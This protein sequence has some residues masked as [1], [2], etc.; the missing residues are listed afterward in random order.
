M[1]TLNLDFCSSLTSFQGDCFN[2]MPNLMRLS[3]C[4]TRISNLWTTVAALSRL[5]SLVELRFQYLLHYN[6][7][8]TSY[9]S[10]S[11]MSDGAADFITSKRLPC[12]G[13]YYIGTCELTDHNFSSNNPLSNFYSFDDIMIHDVPSIKEE[14]SDDSGIDIS[15]HPVFTR[16]NKRVPF[17]NEVVNLST[18][19]GWVSLDFLPFEWLQFAVF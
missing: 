17:H 15:P 2:C 16:W 8:M 14:S 6:D 4:E 5:P 9:T 10:S 19:G 12:I 11:G 1:H 18:P 7:A 3:M 13:E